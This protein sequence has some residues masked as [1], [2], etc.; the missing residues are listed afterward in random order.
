M[1]PP[2]S[3]PWRHRLHDVIY[4]SNTPAGKA[5]DISLL[6]FILASIV[7]VMLDSVP[8]YH[9]EH[10]E[11]FKALEWA[12]T[13]IFTLE[14]LLRLISVE[15]P[16]RFVISPLGLVDLLSI[17]PSYLSTFIPGAHS[18]LV[19]RALRLLRIFRIFKLT[20][21]LS[22]AQFLTAAIRGSA[23]KI[24]IFMLA[25][26]ALT[27]ILGSIMYLVEN[28]ENGFASI[29]ESIYWAVVTITTVGYGD[30]S[31]VTPL[32]RLIAS[33]MM[34]IGYGIIAVPTGILTSEIAAEARKKKHSTEACPACGRHGHDTDA[35]HCKWCGAGL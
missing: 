33:V 8:A 35:R 12:F 6:I 28:G 14:Y 16:L 34:L 20:H 26:V 29:P 21:F 24:A 30:I 7:V 13:V 19:L 32:G 18:L 27:V 23:R 5:F 25:V 11:L 22:E 10:G 9:R 31:P 3:R 2:E 4:E 15:R 17:L 1:S